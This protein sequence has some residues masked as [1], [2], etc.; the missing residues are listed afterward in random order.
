MRIA[1]WNARGIAFPNYNQLNSA[2]LS[3]FNQFDIRIDKTWY[4]KKWS[5]NLY[6]DI[7]NFFNV[8]YLGP[9]TLIAAQND[10]GQPI[11]DV[12]NP[13]F[14]QADYL[15]NESGTVLPT[16]GIILDF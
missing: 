3:N 13:G 9:Q 5:L 14:Y 6:L 8:K 16:I 10:A 1:N 2:R 7:Q 15:P 11:V 4:K 12:N